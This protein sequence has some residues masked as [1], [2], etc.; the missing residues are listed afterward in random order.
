MHHEPGAHF[1]SVTVCLETFHVPPVS[2]RVAVTPSFS[3][4]V[5]GGTGLPVAW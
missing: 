5:I 1:P 3:G 2:T 4:G